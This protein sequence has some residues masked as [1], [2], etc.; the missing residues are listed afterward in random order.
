MLSWCASVKKSRSLV[1]FICYCIDL[2][3]MTLFDRA[4]LTSTDHRFDLLLANH[5]THINIHKPYTRVCS[6][7]LVM[8]CY[9]IYRLQ[10]LNM[11]EVFGII[12]LLFGKFNSVIIKRTQTF[13]FLYQHIKSP[14]KYIPFS[15]GYYF[16][17]KRFSN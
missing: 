9:K 17:V 3:P 16:N 4:S 13:L 15:F 1:P 2:V 6:C 14:W 8:K 7:A 12:I 10:M 11:K 5:K